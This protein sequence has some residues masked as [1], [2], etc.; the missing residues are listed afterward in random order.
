MNNEYFLMVMVVFS[1]GV[2]ITSMFKHTGNGQ[3]SQR[4]VD[5]IEFSPIGP[6]LKTRLDYTN[7]EIKP[8]PTRK[9]SYSF[10]G[11]VL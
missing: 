4:N 8:T 2:I 11:F 5:H 9:G 10:M 6:I 1:I 3:L 7:H